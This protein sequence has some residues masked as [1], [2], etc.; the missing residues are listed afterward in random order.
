MA[1]RSRAKPPWPKDATLFTWI[2]L[3]SINLDPSKTCFASSI[4]EFLTI[5]FILFFL[6]SLPLLL[7]FNSPPRISYRLSRSNGGKKKKKKEKKF[8]QRDD[9]S[10]E[11]SSLAGEGLYYFLSGRRIVGEFMDREGK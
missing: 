9:K 2:F 3:R 10:R 5:L 8:I 4:L 11:R 6:F 1:G 7:L